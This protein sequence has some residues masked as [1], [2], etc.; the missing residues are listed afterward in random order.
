M[1]SLNLPKD[2]QS[3]NFITI[4]QH[5]ARERPDQIAFL[6][7]DAKGAVAEQLSFAQ[8]DLRARAVAAQLQISGAHKQRVLLMYDSGLEFIVGFLGCLYAGAIAVPA[9]P[10]NRRD[11]RQGRLHRIIKDCEPKLALSRNRI[12]QRSNGEGL[13][14]NLDLPVLL[15]D[16]L[17]DGLADLWQPPNL[18]S[19]DIAFLQYTSGSSDLP[20]GVR[21]SHG[22]LI[23]NQQT[24]SRGFGHS[25]Q[26][27]F[28]GW[29]PL[30]H[31]MGLVGNVLQPLY[32]GI[33]SV[34]MSPYAVLKSP[35]E[36][37][38][39]ITK[40]RATTSGGP[41]FAY[42]LCTREISARDREELDLSS[43]SVA[44]N[45]AEPIHAETLERFADTFATCGF[46]KEAL[47]PCYGM[48][49]ATLLVTC[50][51]SAQPYVSRTLNRQA[52]ERGVAEL[53]HQNDS[54]TAVT[55][56]SS[57]TAQ[58]GLRLVIVDPEKEQ[59]LPDYQV[60]EIWVSGTS[61][62]QDYWQPV[63]RTSC[64][65][66]RLQEDPQ[67]DWLRTGDLGFVVNGELFVTGRRSDLIIVR[68]RNCHPQDIERTAEQAHP[69]LLP[70]S[71]AAFPVTI[72]REERVVLVQEIKRTSLQK[73]RE[74]ETAS[75]I[76][77]AVSS[78]HDLTIHEIVFVPPGSV[79]KT[80]S[81]K[82]NRAATKRAHFENR[83]RH[84]KENSPGI[85]F[86]PPLPAP[87]EMSTLEGLSPDLRVERI[88]DGLLSLAAST[89][90]R[91]LERRHR[92]C[93][94]LE[95]GADSLSIIR[96]RK[97]FENWLVKHVPLE[98][99]L[100]ERSILEIAGYLEGET[101]KDQL[102]NTAIFAG[103][104]TEGPASSYQQALWLRQNLE[105][106]SNASNL[107]LGLSIPLTLTRPIAKA[108]IQLLLNRHPSLLSAFSLDRDDSE[109]LRQRCVSAN[110]VPFRVMNA[111]TW[112]QGKLDQ[113]L[114]EEVGRK[115]DLETGATF[116]V[117]L[118]ELSQTESLLVLFAHH[119]VM[120]AWSVPLVLDSLGQIIHAL[121]TNTQVPPAIRQ[122]TSIDYAVWQRAQIRGRRGQVLKDYWHQ[123]LT[124]LPPLLELP[125]DSQLP[126]FE[127]GTETL[128]EF[129]FPQTLANEIK[130]LARA[131]GYTESMIYL[132][133]L[134]CVV[135]RYTE[136]RDISLTLPVAVRPDGMESLIG[137]AVNPLP[138]RVRFSE[139]TDFAELLGHVRSA[140]LGAL[141][142]CEFPLTEIA[143]RWRR[144]SAS[145]SSSL[146][147]AM[148]VWHGG[149]QL[150][151]SGALLAPGSSFKFGEI[152][153]TVARLP[154]CDSPEELV[155]TLTPSQDGTVAGHIHF[156]P[157]LFSKETIVRLAGHLVTVLLDAV[158]HPHKKL[159]ELKLLTAAELKTQCIDWN[160]RAP[161]KMRSRLPL[162]RIMEQIER[163]PSNVAVIHGDETVS[164]ADLGRRV[165]S[166]AEQLLV[167]G[168]RRGDAV[169]VKL[170]RN[171]DLVTALLAIWQ[172]GATYVPLDP[173]LPIA[174]LNTYIE[175][176]EC[177]LILQQSN[178]HIPKS[179][180]AAL[181]PGVPVM[182][183]SSPASAPVTTV[184]D[185]ASESDLAYILFTSGSTGRPKGVQVEQSALASLMAWVT[186]Q[187][188]PEELEA[189]LAATSISFDISLFELLA[190]LLVGGSVVV[191]ENILA[192]PS[193]HYPVTLLNTVPS[194]A[195]ALV[196]VD[197]IPAS[198]L[199]LNLAGEHLPQ[200]LVEA[201]YARTQVRKIYDLYGPT[202]DTVF[203][204]ATLR[205]VGGFNNIGRPIA[206]S[207]AF[208]TDSH[209]QPVPIGV[210]GEL[211]LGGAKLARGY[212]GRADLTD[213]SFLND[214]PVSE[215][216]GRVYRTG[217][218][219]RQLA[220]GSLQYLGRSD[221]QIKIRGFRV[222]LEEIEQRLLR[223]S[224]VREAA[225][226]TQTNAQGDNRIVA[227]IVPTNDTS[228][229][230]TR[231][232]SE[233]A[234]ELPDYMV[235]ASFSLLL[236]LPRTENGKLDRLQLLTECAPAKSIHQPIA[237]KTPTEIRLFK[238]WESH[239][240]GQ[241]FGISDSFFELGGDSL[242]ALQLHS[243]VC[244]EFQVN[245]P[246]NTVMSLPTIASLAASLDLATT[247]IPSNYEEVIV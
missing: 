116:R 218:I 181:Q 95:L 203:S 96:V 193:F 206:G 242:R 48:A 47:M 188:E 153:A 21:V 35:A 9:Y 19:N 142:H 210:A 136:S 112:S 240:P 100:S 133:G 167:H 117:L 163:T 174:R 77:F 83:L 180:H 211:L 34:L 58:N 147:P 166:L 151:R 7:L 228:V 212:I 231:L 134:Q 160:R 171:S 36:W 80:S 82:I 128:H 123:V 72:E 60:G 187:Y 135:H 185:S 184:F 237:P 56:V 176:A 244:R 61:V 161:S 224:G 1:S 208:V 38:R 66:A 104:R 173:A 232:R 6:F 87:A 93:N 29:V 23:S 148:F 3:H 49:E 125:W 138:V 220:D 118:Y 37:L 201:L 246:P 88:A 124:P 115:F 121:R 28:V 119:L 213:K 2:E 226:L 144:E 165:A 192:L 52:L 4:A 89:L 41:N 14:L 46:R 204:T 78:R 12:Q 42:E 62:A 103:N 120:D 16:T 15:T 102:N 27:V 74:A 13:G 186:D 59:I 70:H 94:L 10:P 205:K 175:D 57:G 243:T 179:S 168:I 158:T 236:E 122:P 67:T 221:Q 230:P 75:A 162:E 169:G 155:L 109:S 73:F 54:S 225:V 216:V 114:L 150:L 101:E 11:G 92:H 140:L 234:R 79:T 146:Q 130:E 85:K 207:R 247:E 97:N 81:G 182:E 98:C 8:L 43:W 106:D 18:N 157:K 149:E 196:D 143:K 154:L 91:P 233:L 51:S 17:D 53:G 200:A 235:P 227:F 197:G 190:P 31:D 71:N 90:G 223:L 111:R 209:L 214:T 30:F 172:V 105:P 198:V 199:T 26:T 22:N 202:E 241:R 84:L 215:I 194:A 139:E 113:S 195:A 44:F 76:R 145:N 178:E 170:P 32:L 177:K 108:A 239:F 45:G 191:I 20:A 25:D 55:L 99:L 40:Y 132:A 69:D 229:S 33:L 86:D 107:A 189:V 245:I 164:Y 24:I 64:F 238:I 126:H 131:G 68:G 222:E 152:Q 217:D 219:V 159:H 5:H 141:K 129:Q 50:G 110:P 156:N 137:Y 63:P 127:P 65:H 39:A 183:V